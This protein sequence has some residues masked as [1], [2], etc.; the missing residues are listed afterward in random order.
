ML[1]ATVMPHLRPVTL[2]VLTLLA[3]P[4][5]E[6]AP[7]KGALP[8]VD[9]GP[10]LVVVISVDQMRGDYVTDF[11]GQWKHGLRRLFS[12]GAHFVNARFPYLHT[13]TCPGHA[14]IG[15]GAF[16]HRHGMIFNGWWVDAQKK[17]V[18]CT[19]DPAARNIPYAPAAHPQPAAG[20]PATGHSP[21]FMR[22]P[23][24]A[25]AMKATLQPPPRVF[26]ASFKPRSAI[27]MVGKAGDVVTFF[28][29]GG[30]VTSSAYATEP[31]PVVKKVLAGFA[32]DRVVRRPWTRFLPAAAYQGDDQATFERVPVPY[33]TNTLP[34]ALQPAVAK[35]GPS[36][37]AKPSL[38]AWTESPFPD[39]VLLAL[40]RAGLRDL[41]LGQGKSR[42]MLAIS[43]S[44]LDTVGHAFGPQ[45]HEVQDA[46]ARLDALLGELLSALDRSV[47][48]DRYLLALTA[49]HGVAPYPEGL[50]AAGKDA[51]R[52]STQEL[53]QRLD[54]TIAEELG[55]G[56]HV[57]SVLYT[58]IYLAPG[59]Y[60][61]L[62]AKPG[63][64]ARAMG[65][66]RATPGVQ[67]VFS[68]DEL[69]D[70]NKQGDPLRRAAALSHYPGR[71]GQLVL[72]TKP[73]WLTTAT[74]T[75]HGTQHDY[76]QHVPVVLFG[77]GV[78]P[79]R[80]Q[81][82][83]SPADVA[84]TLAAVLGVPLPT[85]EGRVLE[86]GLTTRPAAPTPTPAPAPAR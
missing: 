9:P 18:P 15:T 46:L 14:T 63:A 78:R 5:V 29:H 62:K 56:R 19:E 64:L 41:R 51:G 74:G 60:D 85:A 50:S 8:A 10:R 39:E 23:T 31:H 37:A 30:W 16:P 65:V 44:A 49:D 76:D 13:V 83:A 28:D 67:A 84:P 38:Q 81:Q 35:G 70:P 11:G 24:V 75:T 58:D 53:R 42:D 48:K 69:R 43:F 34:K 54:K 52:V 77:A 57:A 25:E 27:G 79:G 12:Q 80:Y 86:E 20:A 2:G 7:R 72:A 40:A 82:A 71:S 6:G 47:G 59:V 4:L 22:V 17:V 45:S 26:S 61:R 68:D 33:W 66:V 73:H 21:H 3:A 36:V 32:P 55:P 1:E